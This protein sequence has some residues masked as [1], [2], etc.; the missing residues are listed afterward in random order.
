[1]V[2]L[3][4]TSAKG[5]SVRYWPHTGYLG[6]TPV[7]IEGLVATKRDAD[8]KF[9]PTRSITVSV[10]CYESR[11]GRIGVLQS[12]VLVDYTDVLWSK[13]DGKEYE[14]IGDLEFPFRISIPVQVGGFSTSTFVE[15]RCVWRVEAILT[16]SHITGV[17][18]RQIK[19]CE[20][21]L[22]RY[23]LLPP[24]RSVP[25]SRYSSE[26]FLNLQ[27]NKPRAPR[28]NYSI[29]CP[30]APIGPMD[31][32]SVPISLQPLD[33]GVVIRSASVLV[34]RRIQLHEA[35]APYPANSSTPLSIP[36]SPSS[37]SLASYS[38][39][40]SFQDL[41]HRFAAQPSAI[42]RF[43]SDTHLH[44]ALASTSSLSS[45][46][47]TI[48]PHTFY[49]SNS[50]SSVATEVQPLINR[51]TPS[52]SSLLQVLPKKTISHTIAE[53]ESSGPF[54]RSDSGVWSKTLTIEWP[55]PKSSGRWAIGETIRSQLVSVRF[56]LRVKIVVTTPLGNDTLE[57]QEREILVV[58]TNESERRLALSKYNNNNSDHNSRSKSKSPRRSRPREEEIPPEVPSSASASR[59]EHTHKASSVSSQYPTGVKA[60]SV[61]RRPHTSAG[62]RD[63]THNFTMPR[64]G[65]QSQV[66]MAGEDD[67]HQ[68][69]MF[70]RW[71]TARAEPAASD[72]SKNVLGYFFPPRIAVRPSESSSSTS[73][74]A[75]MSTSSVS[76]SS[77]DSDD[78]R[79]WEAELAQI[80]VRSR[81]SSD[82][83]GFFT[84]KKRAS[85]APP[86]NL[87]AS[88][89]A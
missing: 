24:L 2:Q 46:N 71:K 73:I 60:K 78:V 38:P 31:L 29:T 43:A 68:G 49:P 19:H 47:P 14:N 83:L 61:S 63:K 88:G 76:D 25:S 28:I 8:Q 3:V 21:A 5:N 62:P 82:M 35:T 69:A 22:T 70:R 13:P 10:R 52:S 4:L 42:H 23:D 89:R 37:P 54:A 55:A 6:L 81:R 18:T 27:T 51:T 9:L 36:Q 17:G 45:S 1:M 50:T 87:F 33:S 15:Y 77:Q 48:T 65:V 84:K 57:L 79:E 39:T 72:S 86:N 80:E 75:S 85:A 56:F 20:I 30:T 11:I 66:V 32:V 16:H 53:V 34:E 41:S 7:I 26:P 64:S 40:A 44:Q 67:E 74:T 58:S 12:N 59:A